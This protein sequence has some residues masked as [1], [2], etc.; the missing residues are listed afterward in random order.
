MSIDRIENVTVSWSPWGLLWRA[1]RLEVAR[2]EL[3]AELERLSPAALADVGIERQDI[4]AFA[5]ALVRGETL[6]P[7][8]LRR[9]AD[10]PVTQIGSDVW[11]RAVL[12]HMR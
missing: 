10:E 3:V 4:R 8:H 7:R 6:L 2:A 11:T 9:G 12:L 1:V 5:R